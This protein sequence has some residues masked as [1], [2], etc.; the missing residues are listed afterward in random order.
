MS[1]TVDI[2]QDLKKVSWPEQLEGR[3]I[4]GKERD[5]SE[6]NIE[7]KFPIVGRFPIRVP[8][9]REQGQ[10]KCTATGK[11]KST[12]GVGEVDRIWDLKPLRK[13]PLSCEL[14]N[15]LSTIY[16]HHN[17]TLL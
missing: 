5:E 14:L 4:A 7:L 2:K 16:H 11:K 10:P 15:Q 17:L 1:H 8:R 12:S 13:S 3:L 9:N 6:T